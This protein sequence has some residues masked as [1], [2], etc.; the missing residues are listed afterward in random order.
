MVRVARLEEKWLSGAVER[1]EI[2]IKYWQ[3][4]RQCWPVVNLKNK[5]IPKE[6]I[7]W[8]KLFLGRML[9]PPINFL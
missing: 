4:H 7:T 9:K 1:V 2:C 6:F 8:I 3:N 5:K